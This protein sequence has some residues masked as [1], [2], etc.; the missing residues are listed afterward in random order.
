MWNLKIRHRVYGRLCAAVL[1]VSGLGILSQGIDIHAQDPPLVVAASQTVTYVG[2]VDGDAKNTRRIAIVVEGDQFIAYSCSSDANF[3]KVY[4]IWFKGSAK[5][6]RIRATQDNVELEG[7]L[8]GTRYTGT[9]TA[10]N[11]APLSFK[12]AAIV[13]SPIAGLYRA[14]DTVK[15]ADFVIGWIVDGNHNVVGSCRNKKTGNQAVLKPKKPLP[16]PPVE[17]PAPEEVAKQEQVADEVLIVQADE[18]AE[19]QVQAQKVRSVTQVT[20]GKKVPLPK[21]KK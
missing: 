2:P 18:E 16:P 14:T 13:R 19:Q 6:G 1:L 5:D 17:Q 20:P 10:K 11:A 12:A 8:V 21:K 15:D 9:L 7:S 3:N 4:A